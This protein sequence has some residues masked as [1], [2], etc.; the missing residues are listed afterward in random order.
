MIGRERTRRRRRAVAEALD[1]ELWRWLLEQHPILLGLSAQ[2]QA[3]LRGL[4]ERFLGGK[5]FESP[6]ADVGFE[7]CAVVAVQAVLPILELGDQ[8]VSGWRT[9]VLL[10]DEYDAEFTE[11][12]EAGVVHEWR[13]RIAGESWDEG[14]LTL[15]L[16]D[17]DASGWC[18]G[19]N[20]VIHE[21]AHKLDLTDGAMNGKPRLHPDQDAEAWRRTFSDVFESLQRSGGSD[22][23][24]E[25]ALQDPAEFFASMSELFFELPGP[26]SEAL[27]GM[28][29]Q[30]QAFYRQDPRARLS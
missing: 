10:P 12:D 26:L 6:A 28:Y 22:L 25:Y 8:W 24:D 23:V 27:P 2:Q 7:S 14:P 29:A 16:R 3:T 17:V 21:V 19:F 15:S 11:V 20:V 4:T 9:V 1:G 5:H 30:L 13:D 18:D